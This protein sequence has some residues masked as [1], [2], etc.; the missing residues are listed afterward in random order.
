MAVVIMEVQPEM[1]VQM[2]NNWRAKTNYGVIIT[3]DG[4]VGDSAE[5]SFDEPT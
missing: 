5:L 2:L 4:E 1:K 3:R